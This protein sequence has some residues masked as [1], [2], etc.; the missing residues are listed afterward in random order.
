M[1]KQ[2]FQR[3]NLC[4][5]VR[6]FHQAKVLVVG[7][8]ILDRYVIGAAHRISPEAP[9]PVLT[10]DQQKY[11]LGGAANVALNVATLGGYAYLVGVVGH[12]ESAREV[13]RLLFSARR[14]SNMSI[15][16]CLVEIP[17]R[18]TTTKTRYMAGSHQILRVDH[19][20][21]API[22]DD[23]AEKLITL[24]KNIVPL[25]NVVILSDYAKGVLSDAVLDGILSLEEIDEIY[26]K[27]IIAD[28]KRADLSMYRGATIL[29]PNEAELRL[30]TGITIHTG[31]DAT[32]AGRQALQDFGGAAVVVTRSAKGCSVVGR[33]A[34]LHLP[35]FAKDVADVS[36][37]GDTLVAT[38]A[39]ATSVGASLED[40]TRLANYGA[41]IAVGK[42]GT[43]TVSQQEILDVVR[44]R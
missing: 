30:A 19:E 31:E 29:T 1:F 20:E 15:S 3:S 25:V 42:Q 9:I 10:P 12:D 26:S 18:P 24:V 37:A 22:A 38:L 7:D 33:E 43:A 11:V 2:F 8:I 14:L 21:T 17:E 44:K 27:T 5:I 34:I 4:K 39:V 16:E 36:G 13:E 41:G 35:T 23:Y 32:T 6:N 28:P 40:A